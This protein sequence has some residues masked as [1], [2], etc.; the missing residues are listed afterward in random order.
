[1]PPD[2]VLALLAFLGLLLYA[3]LGG[4]VGTMTVRLFDSDVKRGSYG[5]IRGLADQG[6]DPDAWIGFWFAAVLWPLVIGVG[7]PLLIGGVGA[8]AVLC[9]PVWIMHRVGRY[10]AAAQIKETT[11]AT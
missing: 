3:L 8:V 1:M 6:G 4:V 10:V 2:P 5:Y 7:I 9:G 11:D